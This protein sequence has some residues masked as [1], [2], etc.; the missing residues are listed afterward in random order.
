MSKRTAFI[1][2][3]IMSTAASAIPSVQGMRDHRR[4]LIVASPSASDATLLSQRKALAGWKQGASER[5]VSVVQITGQTVDGA[6]DSAADLRS[7]YN[8][9]SKTFEVVL[10]GKDGHIAYRSSQPVTGAELAAKI[11]AM[12]MR[13][14]GGR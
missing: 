6:S 3:T 10:V 8:L 14:A 13:R 2:F 9:P 7:R 5:D 4:V 12:P 1:A 11:D